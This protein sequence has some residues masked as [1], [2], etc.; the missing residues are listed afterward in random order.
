MHGSVARALPY[1][2]VSNHNVVTVPPG[3]DHGAHMSWDPFSEAERLNVR[4]ERVDLAGSGVRGLCIAGADVI[5]LD[6]GLDA[7]EA[8]SVLAHELE[9]HSHGGVDVGACVP[10]AL[11]LADERWC[12]RQAVRRLVQ[13][14]ELAAFL[15]ELTAIDG[16]VTVPAVAERFGVAEWVA[17][18]S[19]EL[20][21]AA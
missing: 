21:R 9:H 5:L 6:S 3:D 11:R 19:I 4:V 18:V 7:A 15:A 1:H 20:H 12:D 8:R 14:D 10:H 17:A 16:V 2:R 13:A